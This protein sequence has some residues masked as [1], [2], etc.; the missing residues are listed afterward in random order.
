MNKFLPFVGGFTFVMVCAVI[1]FFA[2]GVKWGTEEC[3]LFTIASFLVAVIGGAGATSFSVESS[4][5]KG[6]K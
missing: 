6:D 4:V 1:V 5:T 2:G 3:G